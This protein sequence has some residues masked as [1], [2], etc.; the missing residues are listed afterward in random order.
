M[1]VITNAIIRLCTHES[2]K[3]CL[4]TYIKIMFELYKHGNFS[5]R[6]YYFDII[7]WKSPL[8]F[9]L[10][11]MVYFSSS[12]TEASKIPTFQGCNP[13]DSFFG[14]ASIFPTYWVGR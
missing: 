1:E 11:K 5:L 6:I 8:H 12:D 9:L 2:F 7:S 13:S 4:Y 10:F 3:T 14:K